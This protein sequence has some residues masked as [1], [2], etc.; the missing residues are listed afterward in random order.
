M[1]SFLNQ[2]TLHYHHQ[3]TLQAH[4]N[5]LLGNQNFHKMTPSSQYMINAHINGETFYC[6]ISNFNFHNTD[7]TNFI[8]NRTSNFSHPKE[9]IEVKLQCGPVS[10]IIYKNPVIFANNQVKFFQLKVRDDGDVQNMFRTHEHYGFNDIDL[11]I[12]LQQTQLS[13]IIDLS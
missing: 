8:I 2:I 6:E 3:N 5:T 12:L 4:E 7:I 13:Q 10:Q 9:R 1:S 11:Y